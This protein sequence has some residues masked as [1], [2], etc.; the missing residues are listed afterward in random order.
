MKFNPKISI[1]I[2]VY[3]GS[4]YIK[5]AID[6]ALCQTYNNVEV[7]VVN[8]GSN[9]NGKTDEIAKSYRDKIRYFYKENGGVGSALN[10][11][12]KIMNGEYFSWL[13]HD[14]VY[15]L[16][17]LELQ[18]NYL[19]NKENKKRIILYSDYQ[20][21]DSDSNFIKNRVI[22]PVGNDE[23]IFSLIKYSYIHGGTLLIPKNAFTESGLFNEKLLTTQDYD[24]WFRF[25][26]EGYVFEHIPKILIK[27]R[28]HPEQGTRTMK[29][30]QLMEK[31]KL[32]KSVLENFSIE[33]ICGSGR[34]KV[35]RYLEIAN[36][37]KSRKLLVASKNA[38]EFAN[39]SLNYKNP[40]VL[41]RGIFK[42]TYYKFKNN[43]IVIKFRNKLKTLFKFELI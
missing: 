32:F 9:D 37:L 21:I 10:F 29:E 7:I 2:P 1:I 42:I 26:K 40:F 14:D 30:S 25:L 31:N 17:K 5:E 27:Y 6:S 16:N 8:D 36:N 13:S 11:G 28:V 39:R 22:K 38:E 18:V 12:I 19:Q 20:L 43:K 3:N 23:I 33:E 34:Q 4:K 41:L 35:A 24:L 15:L